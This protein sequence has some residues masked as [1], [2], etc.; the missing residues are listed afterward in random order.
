MSRERKITACFSSG[1]RYFENSLG[2]EFD[3]TTATG[4]YEYL[5]GALTGCFYSTLSSFPH[6]S[7]WR[8]MEITARGYKREEVPT[9]LC[10]TVLDITVHGAE[11]EEEV[12]SL[13][14]RA[15]VECS[16][17]ATISKVS[18]MEINTVFTK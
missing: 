3:F 6:K 7:G 1:R 14:E 11:E 9:T 10:R 12:R 4:P 5:L 8:S 13:I 16:I 17:F 15:S 2:T 18:T